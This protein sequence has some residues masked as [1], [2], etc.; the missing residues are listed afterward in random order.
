LSKLG[1][2]LEYVL[3]CQH[4]TEQY[5]LNVQVTPAGFEPNSQGS[6]G[7]VDNRL[8]PPY[9]LTSGKE[10][11]SMFADAGATADSFC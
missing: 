10:D 5:C 1:Q 7:N 9:D 2:V 3:L 4:S 8:H 11:G 6:N